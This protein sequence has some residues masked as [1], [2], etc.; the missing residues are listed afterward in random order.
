MINSIV[1]TTSDLTEW[2]NKECVIVGV[3]K[4]YKKGGV[5]LLIINR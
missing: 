2:Q 1:K 4:R 3:V 5:L